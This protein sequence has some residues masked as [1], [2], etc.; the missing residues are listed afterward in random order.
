MFNIDHIPEFDHTVEVRMPQND[1]VETQTFKARFRVLPDEEEEPRTLNWVAQAKARLRARIV[2]VD[3][4]V[5]G[6][7]KVVPFGD[8]LLDR[9]L[10]REDVR[11]A[12]F[13]AY[14]DGLTEART[15]N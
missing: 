11:I 15:G 6:S 14:A 8:G 3:D 7:G 9:M 4:I 1:R 5:D 12:L 2:S 10:A 13:E